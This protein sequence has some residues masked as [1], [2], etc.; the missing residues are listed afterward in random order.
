[1]EHA[2][3]QMSHTVGSAFQ[4]LE[5][6]IEVAASGATATS[7][8]VTRLAVAEAQNDFKAQLDQTRAESQRRAEEMKRQVDKVAQGL[9][10]L[11]EQLNSFKPAS[12]GQVQG[13]QEEFAASVDVRLT[14]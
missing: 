12:V 5:K 3:A 10:N 2:Q 8:N 6:E 11:T 4:Q 14:L 1:M 13:S 7:E 9:S